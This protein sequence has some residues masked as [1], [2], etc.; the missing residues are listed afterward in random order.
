MVDHRDWSRDIELAGERTT[1]LAEDAAG[2]LYIATFEGN[3][4]KIVPA[5]GPSIPERSKTFRE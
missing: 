5:G 2:E 4:Y 1:S 3:V